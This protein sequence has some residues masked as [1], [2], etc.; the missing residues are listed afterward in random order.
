MKKKMIA[1]LVLI[2]L[3]IN[4][5]AGGSNEQSGQKVVAKV[6]HV[7]PETRATHLGLVR[8]KE[9]VEQRT[10]GSVEIQIFS[11]AQLGGDREAVEGAKLGTIEIAGCG[12]SLFSSSISDFRV[13]DLPFLFISRPDLNK[14]F[15]GPFGAHLLKSFETIGL[16]GLALY[17]SGFRVVSNNTRPINTPDD[18]K[19]LKIRT[20]E[21]PVYLETYR[22]FGANPTPMAI[23]EVF[24]ALQSG[25]IDGQDTT[26]ETHW[27]SKYYEVN[28]Y[29]SITHHIYARWAVVANIDWFNTKLTNDQKTI[30]LDAGA[31]STIYQ[32]DLSAKNED[33]CINQLRAVGAIV[34]I[35]TPEQLELFRKATESIW[36]KYEPQV[37]NVIKI[38]RDS[39]K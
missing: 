36:E 21:N 8:F 18:L 31:E 38:L 14:A 34:N 12:T 33:D 30:L 19:G 6:A 24:T 2:L 3:A 5:F 15:A 28:K 29:L 32:V 23:G 27:G 35:P 22:C 4:S 16:K 1:V 37:G 9:I 13:F 7:S 26:T 25:T 11:N 10:G 17:E 39:L 20:L